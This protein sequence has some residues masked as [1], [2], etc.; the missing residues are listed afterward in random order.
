[1]EPCIFCAIVA[2]DAPAHRVFEND[3]AV[4]FLDIRPVTRGHLLVV[5]REH[6]TDLNATHPDAAADVFR[7]GHTLARAVRHSDLRADGANLVINDGKAAFQTVFHLH[8]HVVPRWH[9]DRFR[10]AAGFVTRRLSEPERVADA[11]RVGLARLDGE[12]TA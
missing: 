7:V 11:V 1:M 10:F 2:G 8:L 4:A 3:H 5:P 9:R 12:P 6:A